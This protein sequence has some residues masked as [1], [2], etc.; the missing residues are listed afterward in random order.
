MNQAN[1][2][3]NAKTIMVQV[4]PELHNALVLAAGRDD[5]SLNSLCRV[6]LKRHIDQLAAS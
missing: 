1:S 2:I 5:R 4:S 6:I 3:K